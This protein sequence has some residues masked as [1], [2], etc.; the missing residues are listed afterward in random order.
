MNDI[1]T[2]AWDE[3]WMHITLKT[4]WESRLPERYLAPL[5]TQVSDDSSQMSGLTR[6]TTCANLSGAYSA[7]TR[8]G[9]QETPARQAPAGQ[10]NSVAEKCEL[11]I[12]SYAPF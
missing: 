9:T 12:K 8:R 7:G 2:P 3:L 10:E 1:A 5:N 4:D 6:G 11:Y